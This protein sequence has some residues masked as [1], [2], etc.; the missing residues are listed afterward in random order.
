MATIIG[1]AGSAAVTQS[2]T[3]SRRM[4]L[5]YLIAILLCG[6]FLGYDIAW[7]LRTLELGI[8]TQIA[9]LP[10]L[11]AL[12]WVLINRL[13]RRAETLEKERLC[14]RNGALGEKLVGAMLLELPD[15]FTV[16]QDVS[17]GFGNIDHI[18]IGPTGL[19]AIDVKSCR[20]KV[21]ADDDGEVL[22]NGKK[23]PMIFPLLASAA[24]L[25]K[26]IEA[27][28]NRKFF[29]RG[30][31][32]FTNAWLEMKWGETR[33]ILYMS[34]DRLVNF[35]RIAKGQ[36]RLKP[37]D[38]RLVTHAIRNVITLTN[39]HCVKE[40]TSDQLAAVTTG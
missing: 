21:T 12:C 20:G 4:L 22:V 27:I 29:V 8:A 10:I 17:F 15:S 34:S 36:Q 37:A 2:V 11:C 33:N 1:E 18:V 19:F 14:W 5:M 9:L 6:L 39:F 32:A 31:V 26:R 38:I 7:Y 30:V 28:S 35:L 16:F 13:L 24:D 25:N 40:R 23:R 3:K